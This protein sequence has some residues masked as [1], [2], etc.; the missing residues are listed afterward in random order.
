MVVVGV[1]IDVRALFIPFRYKIAVLIA[2]IVL[3]LLGG[4]F[5][6]VQ[7][8]I[9]Q[10]ATEDIKEDLKATR[11]LVSRL[12]EDRRSRLGEIAAG[13]SGDELI[14]VILM[15]TTL[16]RV[17]RD[18]IV[19]DEILP[20]YPYLTLLS[21][22]DADG[23]PLA[24]NQASQAFSHLLPTQEFFRE[25][26]KGEVGAGFLIHQDRCEQIIALPL[27]IGA[28]EEAEI[29]GNILVGLTWSKDDLENIKAVSG[30]DV[31]FFDANKIFLSTNVQLI[32]EQSSPTQLFDAFMEDT[33]WNT[34]DAEP[35]VVPIGS[36]RFLYLKVQDDDQ[37]SP[38]YIIAKSLDRQLGFVQ[39]IRDI[40]TQFG[41]AGIAVG[42]LVGFAFALGISR[43]IKMLRA[44]TAE[45]ERGNLDH[46]VHIHTRDEFS[47]LGESFNQM[48]QGLLEKERIRGVMNKVVSKEI[49]DEILEGDLQLGGETKTATILFSDIR[50]FTTLSEG[51][52]PNDLLD[53]LNAYF[54]KISACID[55]HKGN[56]DK[57]LGDAVMALF[58]VPITRDH[59]AADAVF[60]AV[61]MIGA[62]KEF[63]RTLEA[64]RGKTIQIGI[65]INTGALV[66]GLMGASDRLEYTVLGDE[67]NLAARLEGLTKQ[68]G[69]QIIVSESTYAELQGTSM[70]DD[71]AIK[72]RELDTVL[73]KGKTKAIRIYQA[74]ARDELPNRF[75]VFDTRF[76]EARQLL[77]DKKF[78]GSLK[79]LET[80]EADWPDDGPTKVFRARV[81]SYLEEPARYEKEYRDGS[82]IC[83][84]K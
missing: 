45:V 12:M 40:M 63:N 30:A 1:A 57:Y 32:D 74:F 56:I 9:E 49:A 62:L 6:V 43:P 17:T 68:Y 71:R 20:D 75:S 46:R 19:D 83:G 61:D 70:P 60:A 73:V 29:I 10:N 41:A 5:F 67:V 79:A 18:D 21:V 81:D 39:R 52:S 69:V 84:E 7:A 50:G 23:N 38:P 76:Q 8:Q 2:A 4:T 15:D 16:D 44:A 36:E 47:Q 53:L 28:E 58:G 26:L 80:L 35:V 51:L 78:G 13:L 65:G 33:S 72:F 55:A 3:V 64:E 11:A 77:I 66:A 31:A 34:T 54:T 24:F 59:D 14:R 25:S 82:Y 22:A 27:T 48:I 42:V 37:L